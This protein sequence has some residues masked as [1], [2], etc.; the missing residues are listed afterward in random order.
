MDFHSLNAQYWGCSRQRAKQY[1][2][3]YVYACDGMN[4]LDP[5]FLL[6]C[7]PDVRAEFLANNGII[8]GEN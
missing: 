1:A 3:C 6:Q 7:H 4:R 5:V 2:F 8:I